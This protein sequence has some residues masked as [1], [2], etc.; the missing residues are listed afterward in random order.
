MSKILYIGEVIDKTK[1][2]ADVVNK[3][4]IAVLQHIYGNLFFH[5]PLLRKN[6]IIT[7]FNAI[8]GNS[9]AV[10][11]SDYRAIVKLIKEKRVDTVFLSNSKMGRIA[12]V[13]K[14][15]CKDVCVI[16]FF[17]NIEQQYYEEQLKFD[18]GFK[19][20]L[21]ARVV[22]R[23]ELLASKFSDKLIT[24]NHR[25]NRLLKTIYGRTADCELPTSFKDIYDEDKRNSLYEITKTVLKILF[26]GSSF[27]ANNQGVS[28][29]IEKVLPQLPNASLT[30]VG[31][32]M[33][34]VFN[35]SDNITVVG[36]VDDLSEYYYKSDVVVIPIFYGGGMKTK[37]AEAMMY[38][39]PIVASTEAFEGYEIKPDLIGGLAD[40]QEE[41]I[42]MLE[43]MR[44]PNIRKKCS[45]Y[46]RRVF[47]E[48]YSLD[49]SIKIVSNLFQ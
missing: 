25:D 47:S 44:D 11:T 24:L 18:S 48:K 33:D 23:N 43:K 14:N 28:W 41:M 17:H 45:D 42:R 36:Y 30:I 31:K 5:Y 32:G 46:S 49:S 6:K 37:T 29:F 4:N 16:T 19:S 9:G 2:G 34:K 1:T 21:F 15:K 7:L 38:G 12:S 22:K 39:C 20:R 27:F 35:N 13:V 10:R 26:V 3:R 40:T 8:L